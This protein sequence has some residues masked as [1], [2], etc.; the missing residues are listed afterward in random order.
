MWTAPVSDINGTEPSPRRRTKGSNYVFA[1]WPYNTQLDGPN[2]SA[3]DPIPRHPI[4]PSRPPPPASCAPR[5]AGRS[6]NR[7]RRKI[8]KPLRRRNRRDTQPRVLK[9]R[10]QARRRIR[11]LH[12]RARHRRVH[13][14][15]D[16]PQRRRRR[17]RRV[18]AQRRHRLRERVEVLLGGDEDGGGRDDLRVVAEDGDDFVC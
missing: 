16:P 5:Q 17:Q 4:T 3:P 18:V 6:L 14:R 13:Q 9:R 10:L 1:P 2:L 8:T 7:L 12:V 11:I 15:H